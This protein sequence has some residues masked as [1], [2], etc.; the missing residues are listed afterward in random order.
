MLVCLV[1]F[2]IC[3]S[4]YFSMFRPKKSGNLGRSWD[5]ESALTFFGLVI[6]FALLLVLQISDVYQPGADTDL[7]VRNVIA[8]KRK[9]VEIRIQLAIV[10][11]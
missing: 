6:F 5:S 10:L 2:G 3:I 4:S 1:Y 7:M 9:L 11:S 8:K